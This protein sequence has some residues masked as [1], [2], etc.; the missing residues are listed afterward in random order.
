MKKFLIPG[1]RY[2]SVGD[3][4]HFWLLPKKCNCKKQVTRSE[5]SKLVDE[6]QAEII[7][8]TRRR[9]IEAD[10]SRIWMAQQVMVPRVDLISKADVERAYLDGQQAS[11]EYIELVH[12]LYMQNRAKLIV[13]FRPDPW[14]GRTLFTFG[15]DQRS[16]ISYKDSLKGRQEA[17]NKTV[18]KEEKGRTK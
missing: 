18:E 7:Y 16:F 10:Y 4:Q 15:T 6:G 11:I 2:I 17:Y 9:I 8:K 1:E 12:E 13:P 14:E 3:K 5:A